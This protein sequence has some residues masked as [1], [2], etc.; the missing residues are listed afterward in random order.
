MGDSTATNTSTSSTKTSSWA[1]TEVTE[2][3][4]VTEL[5]R[6]F[7]GLS[8]RLKELEG[9]L[10]LRV[11]AGERSYE[12]DITRQAETI[13]NKELQQKRR[14]A[15]A[16]EAA[17]ERKSGAARTAVRNA[18]TAQEAKL[19]QGFATERAAMQAAHEKI[20]TRLRKERDA[21]AVEVS[22]LSHT[23]A[24]LRAQLEKARA[25]LKKKSSGSDGGG[26]EMDQQLLKVKAPTHAL[27]VAVLD[28]QRRTAR[29]NSKAL[30]ARL[31]YTEEALSDARSAAHHTN[32]DAVAAY[33]SAVQDREV[34]AAELT[35]VQ[36]RLAQLENRMLS[37][38]AA[39]QKDLRDQIVRE[40]TA[41]MQKEF[42]AEQKRAGE[43]AK[44]AALQAAEAAEAA[45][46]EA[47]RAHQEE[48]RRAAE[49]HTKALQQRE[50]QHKVELGKLRN[51]W[52]KK[53]QMLQAGIGK[54]NKG[55]EAFQALA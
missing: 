20:V 15:R 48:M 52:E 5:L 1:Q 16:Q 41:A 42:L 2:V 8:R 40:T 11:Q 18:L 38:D 10:A 7:D 27:D 31:R 39:G 36:H 14:E 54:V 46:Y 23:E 6:D 35:R 25:L 55:G 24:L 44:V 19:K 34:L 49:R 17:Q 21:Y 53:L 9:D 3:R 13:W 47:R 32:A 33:H 28:K 50:T 4:A 22:E 37:R 30:R 12:A 29:R 45:S 51:K 26:G 43:R